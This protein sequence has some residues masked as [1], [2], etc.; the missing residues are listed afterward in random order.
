VGR[1]GQTENFVADELRGT[2]DA[3]YVHDVVEKR[4]TEHQDIALRLDMYSPTIK[5]S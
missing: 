4:R 2:P 1:G 3:S 5:A